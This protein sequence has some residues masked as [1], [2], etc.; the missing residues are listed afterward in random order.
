MP[1]AI[2]VRSGGRTSSAQVAR[3]GLRLRGY[4]RGCVGRLLRHRQGRGE[5][6]GGRGG[7]RGV[8]RDVRPDA[9]G[10]GE[11]GESRRHGHDAGRPS[12]QVQALVGVRTGTPRVHIHGPRPT[13]ESR[14]AATREF[15]G[16][17]TRQPTPPRRLTIANPGGTSGHTSAAGYLYRAGLSQVGCARGPRYGKIL[18]LPPSMGRRTP[19]FLRSG[20]TTVRV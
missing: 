2:T 10:H 9:R 11:R 16:V 6:R 13:S 3:G 7:I 4:W 19:K 15:R 18:K 17:F 12:G 1:L 5:D 20:V 8:R 14:R